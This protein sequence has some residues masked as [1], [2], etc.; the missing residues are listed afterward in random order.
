MEGIMADE[1]KKLNKIFNR[2]KLSAFNK[3]GR[4]AVSRVTRFV[5]EG[6]E[7]K[8]KWIDE[9]LHET[10]AKSLQ[11][12]RYKIEIS[13]KALPL[14]LFKPRQIGKLKKGVRRRKSRQAGVKVKIKKNQPQLI[15]GAFIAEMK[16]GENVFKRETEERGSVFALYSAPQVGQLFSSEVALKELEKE[17][18]DRFAEILF[19][20]LE[21]ESSKLK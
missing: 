7:I 5:R 19:Q 21:Y 13:N 1:F 20:R 4:S 14:I 18:T 2:V 10:K 11:D 9:R 16:Y 17:A 8:K 15:A 3:A 6:Y 12:P